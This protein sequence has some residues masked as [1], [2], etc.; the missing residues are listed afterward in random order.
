MRSNL[1]SALILIACASSSPCLSA[2]TG[3]Y[4]VIV[5]GNYGLP[6]A[7]AIYQKLIGFLARP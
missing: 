2:Q 7:S 5:L 3:S 1:C 4:T 6:G